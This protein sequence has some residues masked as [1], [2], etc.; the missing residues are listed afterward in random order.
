[1]GKRDARIDAAI[2]NA[3]EFARPILKRLRELVHKACPNVEETVK[4]SHPSFQYKGLLCGFS[5]FKSHC[6]FGFWK[7][8]IL[9]A[10]DP[11]AKKR[12]DDAMGSFGRIT[13]PS[14]LPSDKI[15]LSYIKEAMRLNEEGINPPKPKAKPRKELVIPDYLTAALQKNQKARKTFE[16]FSYS[17]K[18]EYVEWL[19]EAKREE[20]R[21][22]RLATAVTWMA[23]GKVRNWKYVKC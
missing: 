7:H 4:W 22:E 2:A 12:A 1:M 13:K 8:D 23:E 18:K 5:A 17:N 21:A 6:T 3:P 10:D 11:A 15:L 20:T 14:D 19:T 16:A 9:F